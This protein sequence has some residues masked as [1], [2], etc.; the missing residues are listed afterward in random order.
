[1]QATTPAPT[2]TATATPTATSEAV[3]PAP[4]PR[5][6][7]PVT[8]EDVPLPV[9]TSPAAVSTIHGRPEFSGTGKVGIFDYTITG[10]GVP[11][12]SIGV[13]VND[14]KTTAAYLA[15]A[16]GQFELPSPA[17]TVGADGKWSIENSAATGTY[18]IV[19]YQQISA[20]A[21]S[22]L[23][24]PTQFVLT[25]TAADIP[26][27]VVET[28]KPGQT[29][30]G[31]SST[32]DAEGFVTYTVS[33]TGITGGRIGI[34]VEDPATTASYLAGAGGQAELPSTV[35]TVGSNGTWT[36][37]IQAK[38]GKYALVAYQATAQGYASEWTTVTQ[39]ALLSPTADPAGT[40]AFTGSRG[41]GPML[42]ASIVAV[43][44]GGALLI[45]T[46][47]RRHA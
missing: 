14:P 24:V 22:L 39:F 3:S 42:W 28:P 6:S 43:L 20:G 17:T 1:V 29:I 2:A 44:A 10:T 7:A 13:Y 9:I 33:G 31:T 12:A 23:T 11:G 27:P 47:R 40:L 8:A 4:S 37:S 46:R 21:P 5:A 38:P 36:Y 45:I 18:A 15:G 25:A 30:T 32:G 35:A 34:Y 41:M 26:K 19:A 16:G